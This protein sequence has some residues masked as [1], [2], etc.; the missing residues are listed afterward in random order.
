MLYLCFPNALKVQVDGTY[1]PVG[2][3]SFKGLEKEKNNICIIKSITFHEQFSWKSNL[4][5]SPTHILTEN[6]ESLVLCQKVET[7]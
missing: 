3:K 4:Q 2:E 5:L 1:C 7:D 6:S